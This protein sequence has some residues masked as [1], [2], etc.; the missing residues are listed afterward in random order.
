M[1]LLLDIGNTHTG[2]AEAAEDG[3]ISLRKVLPTAELDYSIARGYNS[4]LISSVVPEKREIFRGLAGV[5]IL[6]AV[7]YNGSMPVSVDPSTLGSDRLANA[8]ALYSGGKYP[9]AAIDCGTAVTLEFVEKEKGF[10][11]GAILPGRKLQRKALAAGTAQ[12]KEYPLS[13]SL[14]AAAGVNT[15]GCIASGIDIGSVGAVEKIVDMWELTLPGR[16]EV[17]YVFTGGDAEFF[18]GIFGK[19]A[20]VDPLLTYRGL[21]EAWRELCG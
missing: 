21:F 18:A 19:K 17:R 5:F 3:I 10:A 12:L 14:P 8:I 16:E 15:A 6:E 20:I 13:E 1:V 2:A 11:G 4:V 7:S 9:A